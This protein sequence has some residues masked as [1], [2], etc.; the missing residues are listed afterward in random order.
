MSG[1]RVPAPATSPAPSNTQVNRAADLMRAWKA[2]R[3]AGLPGPP[4]EDVLAAIDTIGQFR[5]QFA[6]PLTKVVMGLRSFVKT[7]GVDPAGRVGQRLKRMPTIIDKL[8]R[9]P[10]MNLARMHDIGGCRAILP[11]DEVIYRVVRRVKSRPRQVW[12]ILREYDY[13]RSPK[14]S[15]YRGF[16]LIVRRDGRLIEIQLRT[17]SQ[18]RW[19]LN[20]EAIDLSRR[21]GLKEGKGPESLQRLLAISAYAM[22]ATSKGET[23]SQAFDREFER[24]RRAVGRDLK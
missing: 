4:I 5:A 20:V 12:G 22:E 23:M 16:H 10:R 24:L 7:E 19:A 17:P 9:E 13:I 21:L 2:A 14:P 1:D 15:G 3:T 6:G 11:D 8:E 18:H